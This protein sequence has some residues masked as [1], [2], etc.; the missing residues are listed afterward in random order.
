M[1][2]EES[3]RPVRRRRKCQREEWAT[4]SGRSCSAVWMIIQMMIQLWQVLLCCLHGHPS[5]STGP[6]QLVQT[7]QS[8][9]ELLPHA[10]TRPLSCGRT[11]AP[12]V[13]DP[14]WSHSPGP[15]LPSRLADG[16]VMGARIHQHLSLHD[17]YIY[18]QGTISFS[19]HTASAG[20]HHTAA[21]E[22]ARLFVSVLSRSARV[23]MHPARP[24][25]RAKGSAPMI[26]SSLEL[27]SHDPT[28]FF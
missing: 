14:V 28:A 19:S 11:L 20:H 12:S 9:P 7:R 4:S 6:A 17:L 27:A 22:H 1:R 13:S 15:A 23:R 2:A 24:L 18:T 5:F 8:T 25:S 21:C 26:S 16:C 3:M 10:S